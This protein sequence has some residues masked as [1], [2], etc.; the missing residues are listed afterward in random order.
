MATMYSHHSKTLFTPSRTHVFRSLR[1]PLVPAHPG[2][3]GGRTWSTAY[4][5]PPNRCVGP[6]RWR[7]S[8]C[9]APSRPRC[10]DKSPNSLITKWAV[11]ARGDRGRD[12][13]TDCDL[14]CGFRWRESMTPAKP[15]VGTARTVARC[16]TSSLLFHDGRIPSRGGRRLVPECG[17]V[18]FTWK[19]T[20]TQS[21]PWA[22]VVPTTRPNIVGPRA[23]RS[24]CHNI[25]PAIH[26]AIARE[27]CPACADP[28]SCGHRCTCALAVRPLHPPRAWSW[29]LDR[30]RWRRRVALSGRAQRGRR[31]VGVGA[32]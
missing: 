19:N 18:A 8:R 12:F 20:T 14:R 30:R 17:Q 7:R 4:V 10:S 24:S 11:E 3:E 16:T 26:A 28:D 23:A 9:G 1:Y 29:R 6:A 2:G 31:C 25:A 22:P 32:W 5:R 13:E 21:V 15:A 27:V